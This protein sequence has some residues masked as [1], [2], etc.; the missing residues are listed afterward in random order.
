M[1]EPLHIS[2]DPSGTLG[3]DGASPAHS[4]WKSR[5]R[6]AYRP[7]DL[8]LVVDSAPAF[9]GPAKALKTAAGR[10]YRMQTGEKT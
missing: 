7:V 1:H 2:A 10:R 3:R 9:T 6:G 5:P 4:D 8:A